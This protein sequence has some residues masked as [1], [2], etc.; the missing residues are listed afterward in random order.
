[1]DKFALVYEFNNNSPLITYKAVKELEAKNYSKALE[2]FPKALEKYPY[3]AT[4]YFVYALALAY[5]NEVDK[6][7]EIAKKGHDLLGIDSTFEFYT[8]SINRIKREANGISV[9]FDDTVNEVLDES[10]LEHE[11]FD[12]VSKLDLLDDNLDLN[13]LPSVTMKKIQL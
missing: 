13:Q 8:E 10:F 7:K 4:T 12:T 9:N 1:M 2:L 6:A 5:N 3:H 11:E